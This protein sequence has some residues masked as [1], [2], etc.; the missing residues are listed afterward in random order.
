M[1]A[2]LD[3]EVFANVTIKATKVGNKLVQVFSGTSMGEE[4][5]DTIICE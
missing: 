5:K 3:A 2:T 1:K 4:V